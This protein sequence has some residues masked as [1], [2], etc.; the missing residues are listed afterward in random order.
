MGT[1]RYTINMATAGIVTLDTQGLLTHKLTFYNTLPLLSHWV[2]QEL[3]GYI[4][5][6]VLLLDC[7]SG[8]G[9]HC[10]DTPGP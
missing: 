5:G 6:L 10:L 3:H 8:R 9:R 1:R 4:L 2:Q 7:L